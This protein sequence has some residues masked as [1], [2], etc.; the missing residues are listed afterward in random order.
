MQHLPSAKQQSCSKHQGSPWKSTTRRIFR[1]FRTYTLFACDQAAQVLPVVGALAIPN[2]CRP[3]W[4][5]FGAE[6]MDAKSM[7]WC[8]TYLRIGSHP[9]RAPDIPDICLPVI[10][11]FS[12]N[13]GSSLSLSSSLSESELAPSIPLLANQG[14]D[15]KINKLLLPPY[16]TSYEETP[17]AGLIQALAPSL[18]KTRTSM[19]NLTWCRPTHSIKFLQ[20]NMA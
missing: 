1:D 18:Q 6:R 15:N 4:V 8:E 10:G 9:L 13:S 14:Q 7:A 19:Q 16:Y 2:I 3:H 20:I 11:L 12:D 17:S 5:M